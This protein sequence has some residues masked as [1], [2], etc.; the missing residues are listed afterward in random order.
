MNLDKYNYMCQGKNSNIDDALIFNECNLK[1]S[2]EET[3]LGIAID[4]KLSFNSHIITIKDCTHFRRYQINVIKIRKVISN[5][6]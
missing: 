3:I 2:N 6:Q 4:Q 1:T 5:S